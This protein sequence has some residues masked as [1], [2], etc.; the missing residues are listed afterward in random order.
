MTCASQAE[1]PKVLNES[2]PTSSATF[3]K[4]IGAE[5]RC[6]M[7]HGHSGNVTAQQSVAM[8]AGILTSEKKR[9][10]IKNDYWWTHTKYSSYIQK[11]L[12][13]TF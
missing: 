7:E 6:S 2:C 12:E 8:A 10:E 9:K 13:E 1:S 11:Y 5:Q 4:A 3:S